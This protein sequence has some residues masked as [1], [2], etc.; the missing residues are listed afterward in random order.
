MTQNT[1]NT[2]QLA[3]PEDTKITEVRETNGVIPQVHPTNVPFNL[4]VTTSMEQAKKIAR[5]Y[6]LSD[7]RN[8]DDLKLPNGGA[9]RGDAL[10]ELLGKC[11]NTIT[12]VVLADSPWVNALLK[13]MPGMAASVWRSVESKL[14][15][16]RTNGQR[17]LIV[18]GNDFTSGI[19]D[20]ETAGNLLV[21]LNGQPLRSNW[22]PNNAPKAK[23]DKPEGKKVRHVV[24]GQVGLNADGVG[25]PDKKKPT[26]VKNTT[27]R[28]KL[29]IALD[30]NDPN[31]T[32]TVESTMGEFI[33]KSLR[34]RKDA[35]AAKLGKG[36]RP[37]VD[38][39]SKNKGPKP[40]VSNQGLHDD[41]YLLAKN[42]YGPCTGPA[43]LEKAQKIIAHHT[44]IGGEISVDMVCSHLFRTLIAKS[45]RGYWGGFDLLKGLVAAGGQG[46]EEVAATLNGWIATI[47]AVDAKGALIPQ[48]KMNSLIYTK[49]NLVSATI[50]APQ[51]EAAAA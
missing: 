36:E 29:S 15:G 38:R 39:G 9:K 27:N 42:H 46:P 21:L 44:G 2:V 35:K 28:T 32:H 3:A 31:P 30:P 37:Q 19:R 43:L 4:I 26:K 12:L 13:N 33:D 20:A 23:T 14:V 24:E 16:H 5:H 7:V 11:E 18:V 50:E 6:D 49:L 22:K 51:R 47:P 45:N 10:N 1:D 48:P 34:A 25:Q 17:N 41:L 40:M 8:V